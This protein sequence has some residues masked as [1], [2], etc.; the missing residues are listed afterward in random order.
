MDWR[1]WLPIGASL[2]GLGG[3]AYAFVRSGG[4]A[5]GVIETRLEEHDK[6]LKKHDEEFRGV[7]E[8]IKTLKGETAAILGQMRALEEAQKGQTAASNRTADA[9][10][11]LNGDIKEL[12]RR[13]GR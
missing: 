5:E 11:D 8:D 6:D 2:L 1:G 12:L 4:I 13:G 3:G 9:V 7:K 10:R